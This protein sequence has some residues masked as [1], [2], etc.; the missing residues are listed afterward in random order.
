LLQSWFR[1]GELQREINCGVLANVY[2]ADIP[3]VLNRPASTHL[4]G[5]FWVGVGFLFETVSFSRVYPSAGE[6]GSRGC[7]PPSP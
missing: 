5:K 6:Q 3:L 4:P 1:E 7:P 2:R